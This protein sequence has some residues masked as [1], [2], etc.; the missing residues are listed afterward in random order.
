MSE[1]IELKPQKQLTDIN[2]LSDLLEFAMADFEKVCKNDNFQVNM[3]IWLNHYPDDPPEVCYGCLSGAVL[4]Q[5]KMFKIP[6]DNFLD[7]HP[8]Y[9]TAKVANRMRAI[10]HLRKGAIACAAEEMNIKLPEGLPCWLDVD[11][12]NYDFTKQENFDGKFGKCMR[13]LVSYLRGKGL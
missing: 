10:N 2:V 4:Y 13:D 8:N 3:G 12:Y 5:E 1:S 9:E 6:E 11:D 7:V